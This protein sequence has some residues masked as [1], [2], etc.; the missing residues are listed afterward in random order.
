MHSSGNA[1]IDFTQR[2]D[3]CVGELAHVVC[4]GRGE[5]R[6]LSY[7]SFLSS[8]AR[9]GGRGRGCGDNAHTKNTKKRSPKNDL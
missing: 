9:D 8:V 7:Q 5:V 4:V 6:K 1:N 3:V 2:R